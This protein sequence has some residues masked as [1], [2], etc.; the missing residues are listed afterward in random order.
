MAEDD[1]KQQLAKERTEF[2]EDRTFEATERTFAGW[3]RTAFAAIGVGVGFHALFP[4]LEPQWVGK[5]IATLFLVLGAVIAM[6]A[7]RRACATFNRMRV[8]EVAP[9]GTPS[10]RWISWSIV[11]GALALIAAL[12]LLV[13]GTQPTA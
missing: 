10:I 9:F 12:W 11:A 3:M 6:T 13:E 5:L 1:S 2:A 8:H 7:E 4:Q